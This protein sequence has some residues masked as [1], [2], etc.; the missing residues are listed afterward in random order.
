MPRRHRFPPTARPAPAGV[1]A[2]AATWLLAACAA[3]VP[4]AASAQRVPDLP[5][6]AR[7]A[8]V[9]LETAWVGVARIDPFQDEVRHLA[10]DEVNVYVMSRQNLM[11]CFDLITGRRKWAARLGG[12][13][14]PSSPPTSNRDTVFV[15]VGNDI[16]ALDRDTGNENWT[17]P[18]A[19]APAAAAVADDG[20]L[21]VGTMGGSLLAYDL[22][23][24]Q[25]TFRE[26]RIAEFGGGTLSWRYNTGAEI[27]GP[28][29]SDG[30]TIAVAN[31]GGEVV[32]LDRTDGGLLF[33]FGTDLPAV[34]PLTAG[35]GRLFLSS[36]DQN[37]YAIDRDNGRDLWEFVT[38][39]EVRERPRAVGDS[40][41]VSPYG[42]GLYRV[43]A[44]T[45][46]QVWFTPG[47]TG[48]VGVSAGTVYANGSG[49][50]LTLLDR[51]TGRRTGALALPKFPVRDVNDRT[52]RVLLATESGIV[53]CL[54]EAGRDF[55]VFHRY[56]GR[57]PL[58]P[59]FAPVGGTPPAEDAGGTTG[60]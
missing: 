47:V 14:D 30:G 33:K 10:S 52:D 43:R 17:L 44:D 31:R 7:L 5:T 19:S 59:Q 58:I 18:L 32:G 16:Y 51:E 6:G 11:T 26:G 53:L 38:R 2:R 8:T 50:T 12:T 37:L 1:P 20:L 39:S 41:F 9:G 40:V 42:G 49:G 27:I 15:T 36:A 28:P 48:P 25:R 54:R 4:A 55:P 60:P 56:P 57:S 3:A 34:A 21:L 46:D 22:G 13:R 24:I 35:G 45:G 29:V 23:R